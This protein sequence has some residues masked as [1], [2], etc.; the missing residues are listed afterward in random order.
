MTSASRVIANGHRS[1]Q[2]P[3][4]TPCEL[5]ACGTAEMASDRELREVTFATIRA[6]KEDNYD[7]KGDE[8]EAAHGWSVGWPRRGRT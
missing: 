6:M 1:G 3:K 5:Q 4:A 7:A 2:T 8:P